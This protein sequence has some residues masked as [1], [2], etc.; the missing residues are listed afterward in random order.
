[1]FYRVRFKFVSFRLRKGFCVIKVKVKIS[2]GGR[3]LKRSFLLNYLTW[4]IK[5]IIKIIIKIKVIKP[6]I[7][8]GIKV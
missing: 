3:R 2:A 8:F 1:M 6:K 5:T 7:N 4:L